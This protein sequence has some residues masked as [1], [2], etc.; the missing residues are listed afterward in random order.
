[1]NLMPFRGDDLTPIAIGIGSHF[2][3]MVQMK[4]RGGKILL[5]AAAS[6]SIPPEFD[7]VKAVTHAVQACLSAGEFRGKQVALCLKGEDIYIQHQ[8]MVLDTKGDSQNKIKE[9]LRR[10]I[11]FNLDKAEIRFVATGRVYE[12]S[13]FRD[14]LILMVADREVIEKQMA[15]LAAL[16]LQVIRIGAEP[17]GLMRAMLSFPPQ[18]FSNEEVTGFLNVGASKSE[19]VVTREGHLVFSR[20]FP[21]GGEK[22]TQAITEKI[23]LDQKSA[24]RLKEGMSR[25]DEINGT[26]RAAALQAARP[27]TEE[28]CTEIL[29]CFRYYSSIFN[30]E[31]V[32]RLVITGD[33]VGALIDTQML[34]DR[35]GTEVHAWSAEAWFKPEKVLTMKKT[36]DSGF[37]PVVGIALDSSELGIDFMPPDVTEKT[38]QKKSTLL[39]ASSAMIFVLAIVL[40]FAVTQ[41]RKK[42]LSLMRDMVVNR[43][44]MVENK[45]IEVESLS[46]TEKELEQKLILLEEVEPK[47]RTSRI[48]A[49]VARAAGRG[50]YLKTFNM[51]KTKIVKPRRSEDEPP[52]PDR[53]SYMLRINGLAESM[54]DLV[55]FEEKLIFSKA[56]STHKLNSF[57]DIAVGK[58]ILTS[59]S[60]TLTLGL[61]DENEDL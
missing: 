47:V 24:A 1:M 36:F 40:I 61:E 16:K 60:M 39:R 17:F 29:S 28:L 44:N 9:E 25:G 32:S 34:S 31:S 4:R 35:T 51:N 18:E 23:E 11:S 59:F 6:T 19:L 30:R 38:K 50:I 37:T 52:E 48:V 58:R 41:K 26:L 2:V 15:S 49:E 45:N 3:H 7:R 27:V 13:T 55:G 22:Y 54:D 53:Y 57:E 8:R 20:S 10:N 43:C 12:Q 5:Q 33:E 46:N 14:E 56:F 42:K 21:M